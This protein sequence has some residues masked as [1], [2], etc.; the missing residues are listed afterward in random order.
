[1]FINSTV[2]NLK[3]NFILKVKMQNMNNIKN[4]IKLN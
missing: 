1:M 3:F 2:Y 4:T